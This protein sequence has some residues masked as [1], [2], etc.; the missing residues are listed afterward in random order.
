MHTVAHAVGRT[1]WFIVIAF[2]A[3]VILGAVIQATSGQGHT[4]ACDQTNA[5][6]A[7]Q[8]GCASH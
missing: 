3:L 6:L 5:A 1:I 8:T 7:Q 2:I 4:P